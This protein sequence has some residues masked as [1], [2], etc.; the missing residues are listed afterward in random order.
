MIAY[1]KKRKLEI[2]I[3]FN[4]PI[5]KINTHYTEKLYSLCSTAVVLL[6]WSEKT[7]AEVDESQQQGDAHAGNDGGEVVVK[8]YLK[9]PSL[10]FPKAW[11]MTVITAIRGFTTQNWRVA[12][13]NK[14]Q[15]VRRSK[16]TWSNKHTI[17]FHLWIL[18]KIMVQ[19]RDLCYSTYKKMGKV[20]FHNN[21]LI[22][23]P[24]WFD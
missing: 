7:L 2:I 9:S 15:R 11:R 10:Y 19:V 22:Y 17:L 8:T 5:M 18:S 14:W 24:Q 21:I 20:D 13:R 23:A 1:Y 6:L 3:D 12:W 4:L 16:Q